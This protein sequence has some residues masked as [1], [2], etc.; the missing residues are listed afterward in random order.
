MTLL[1]IESNIREYSPIITISLLETSDSGHEQGEQPVVRR[2]AD[3]PEVDN[4]DDSS[5]ELSRRSEGMVIKDVVEHALGEVC[6]EMNVTPEQMGYDMNKLAGLAAN[7]II[8]QG[9]LPSSNPWRE[10]LK[11]V[12][13]AVRKLVGV[14][15][16]VRTFIA[17]YIGSQINETRGSLGQVVASS[18]G[19]SMH[20]ENGAALIMASEAQILQVVLEVRQ[21]IFS[22]PMSNGEFPE[23]DRPQLLSRLSQ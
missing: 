4:S 11:S 5:T 1:P 16:D 2:E 3:I 14:M 7:V 22:R 13:T 6:A 20:A 18:S 15:V 19:V 8:K 9:V 17:G 10:A 21:D 23:L 12:K